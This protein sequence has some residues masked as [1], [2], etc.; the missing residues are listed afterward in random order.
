M[1]RSLT[2]LGYAV[3]V[4]FSLG[5]VAGVATH[6]LGF[7]WLDVIGFLTGVWGVWWQVRENVWNWPIQ[8]V[9]SAVYVVVFFQARLSP[10]PGSTCSRSVS[11][12]PAGTGGCAAGRPH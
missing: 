12:S 5:L 6:R 11:T 4:L 8:L 10:T 3:A 2:I 9:S 7:G 1:R